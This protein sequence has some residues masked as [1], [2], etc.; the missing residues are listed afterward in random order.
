MIQNIFHIHKNTKVDALL[1]ILKVG[2]SVRSNS[3]DN[4]EITVSKRCEFDPETLL[5]IMIEAGTLPESV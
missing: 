3:S 4:P 2:E 1:L 5:F